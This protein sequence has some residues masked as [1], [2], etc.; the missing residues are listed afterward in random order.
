MRGNHFHLRV[1]D[2]EETLVWFER[3]WQVEPTH[4]GKTFAIVPF[5]P[6]QLVLDVSDQDSI[7]T[8]GFDSADCD[9]DCQ[10][11]VA[12]GAIVLEDPADRSWGV[13]AAYIKGP[14]GLTLEIEQPLG[15][16]PAV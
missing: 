1:R 15:D 3:V 9:R 6:I 12:R 8:L 16:A 4:T 13:R 11:V 5:G 2:L 14:A 10:S 7:A